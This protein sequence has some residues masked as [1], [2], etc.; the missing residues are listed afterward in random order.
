M[1]KIEHILERLDNWTDYDEA[2][3]RLL[4]GVNQKKA[5]ISRWAANK[6]IDGLYPGHTYQIF[7]SR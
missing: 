7:A 3:I 5:G 4:L 1:V 6:L 2:Q